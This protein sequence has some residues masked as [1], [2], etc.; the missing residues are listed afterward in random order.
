MTFV[1]SCMTVYFLR[2]TIHAL[3][4]IFKR[5]I[6]IFPTNEEYKLFYKIEDAENN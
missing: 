5:Q 4:G 2:M 1:L 3:F 6:I